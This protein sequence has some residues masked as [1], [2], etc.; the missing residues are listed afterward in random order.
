MNELLFILNIKRIIGA[1]FCQVKT[2]IELNHVR[3]KII[4]GNQKWNGAIPI[5]IKKAEFIIKRFIDIIFIFLEILKLIISK[6]IL[7]III[8]DAIVCT[9]KYFTDA[10]D[11]VILI[12]LYINGIIAN[13]FI[14]KPIHIPIQE[15]AEIEIN[16]LKINKFKNKNLKFLFIKKRILNS[17]LGYEPKSFI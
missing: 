14:S 7:I 9:I 15:V 3:P 10:S 6:V 12:L 17:Y 11:E 8:D 13:K 4:S 2:I 1:I 5:L 16:V